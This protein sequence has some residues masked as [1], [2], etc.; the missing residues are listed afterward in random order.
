MRHL[1]Q[2]ATDQS[3]RRSDF[4]KITVTFILKHLCASWCDEHGVTAS[5]FTKWKQAVISAIDEKLA[6]FQPN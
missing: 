1:L 3:L 5:L 4:K 2:I 6:V